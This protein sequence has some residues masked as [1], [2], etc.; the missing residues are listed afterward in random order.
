MLRNWEVM[1]SSNKQFGLEVDPEAVG[2]SLAQIIVLDN[3]EEQV[4]GQAW[5]AAPNKL[6]TCAHV[7]SKYLD[8]PELLIVKFLASGNAYNLGMG[9]KI[10]LHPKFQV[11]SG[12]EKLVKF[13][14]VVLEVE[15]G[16][17]ES[18]ATPIPVAFDMRLPAQESLCAIRYPSHLGQ[19]TTSVSP[20]AQVGRFLGPL[21]KEDPYHLLHD[22][23]LAPGDSGCPLMSGNYLVAIH[24]GDTATLPGLNLPTT[25]IRL[26]ISVDALKE[27]GIKGS[28]PAA[29]NRMVSTM[30]QGLV[31][32]LL[33]GLISFVILS[34]FLFLPKL[35][36][37]GKEGSRIKP[38]TVMFTKPLN[39]YKLAEEVEIALR[40]QSDCYVYLF[41][42]EDNK[43]LVLFPPIRTDKSA[44]I[45]GG[46]TRIVD[47][48][49]IYKLRADPSPSGKLHLL[50]LISS[51]PPVE[52]KAIEEAV[53]SNACQLP[54]DGDTLLQR[55]DNL[56]TQNPDEVFYEVIDAPRATITSGEEL[57][58]IH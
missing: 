31:A 28:S 40:T 38:I 42:I 26:A 55:I 29:N 21:K 19:F 33:V 49:G 52:D 47:G 46:A 39:G 35:G 51:T 9:G 3:G 45:E 30:T 8:K 44:R 14:L 36:A 23:A 34:G 25:A 43:A 4:I 18:Q 50:A 6:V 27:L 32:F 57:K 58:P 1:K 20:V 41:Y 10:F 56:R 24:C 13:D 37:D 7:V 48:Y 16:L 11:E 22:L 54:I 12:K 5:L 17:P 2:S 53:K 15:L